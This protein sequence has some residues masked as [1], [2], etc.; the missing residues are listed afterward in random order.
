MFSK[1]TFVPPV[2]HSF[3]HLFPCCA[4]IINTFVTLF[5][6]NPSPPPRESLNIQKN[7]LGL[8][9]LG[10]GFV[11][12]HTIALLI[13]ILF[14]GYRVLKLEIPDGP[15]RAYSDSH[16]LLGIGTTGMIRYGITNPHLPNGL[17]R[18]YHLDE[19]SFNFWGIRSI[20]SFLF[21]F[22]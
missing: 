20:F 21:H 1:I 5:T 16:G 7:I 4:E 10:I 12:L 19:S 22:L 8:I 15:L 18:H 11:T 14:S 13:K 6:P 9:F 2:P 17:S 3:R